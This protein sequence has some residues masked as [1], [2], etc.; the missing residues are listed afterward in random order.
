MSGRQ[1]V[2]ASCLGGA[3]AE[4][5]GRKPGDGKS[6]LHNKLR[7]LCHPSTLVGVP[8]VFYSIPSVP[9]RGGSTLGY[10]SVARETGSEFRSPAAHQLPAKF[11]FSEFLEVPN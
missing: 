7:H 8:V 4:T 9:P 11:Q 6:L 2:T 10:D 3:S 1:P 5:E